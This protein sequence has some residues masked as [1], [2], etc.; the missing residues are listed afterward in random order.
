ME[1]KKEQT[2]TCGH[3]KLVH[4]ADEWLG[5]SMSNLTLK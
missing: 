2:L 5:A 3:L 1:K 4:I